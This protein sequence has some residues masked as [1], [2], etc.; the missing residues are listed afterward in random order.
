[1]ATYGQ[2]DGLRDD[3]RF[4]LKI[5]VAIAITNVAAFSMH[6]ALGRSTLAVPAIYHLHAL[7]YMGWVAIFVAQHWL[8][9]SGRIDG[10]RRL[11]RLA[12]AW[13]ALMIVMG[14][15]ITV[16]VVQ[17][18]TT[19]FFFQPQHFLIANPLTLFAFV[20]LLAAA[21][22]L[23]KR[24]DWHQRLHLCAMA[25]ILGPAF[26]RLLPAPFMIPYAFEITT[27]AGLVFPLIAI[28][29]EW[30]AGKVHPAWKWG[31]P[32]LPLVL[33]MASLV[34]Y[35]AL[36]TEVYHWVTA[37]TPGA[38]VDPLAFGAPPPGL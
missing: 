4:F 11:G 1:M 23:R 3:G 37:G 27:L 31:M 6:F 36:A 2:A 16:T 14:L 15:A 32:A 28:V 35:S 21:V 33:L 18:G 9:A 12:L 19:P 29:R 24:T 38:A 30:R 20:G 5:A 22:T 8:A 7:T 34:G 10:H 17:R 26:G 25:M 13:V